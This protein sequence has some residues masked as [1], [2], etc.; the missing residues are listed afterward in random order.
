MLV[1]RG[2]GCAVN[3]PVALAVGNFDGVHKG[4]QAI[5][6]R[7][8]S[9]AA[10]RRLASGVLT[11]EPHPREYFERIRRGAAMPA[12]GPAPTRLTSLREKLELLQAHGLDCVHVQRFTGA[13][14]ALSPER[15]VE[16]VLVRT[17]RAKWVLVGHDFRFGARRA[18]DV[19]RLGELASKH[20]FELAVMPPVVH[21][22]LRVSSGAVREA[23]ARGDLAQAESLLGRPYSISGRVVHGDK[24]GRE[25][26]CSTAN[27]QLKH[28]HPPLTGIFAVLV[29][30]VGAGPRPGVASLGVRPTVKADGAAPVL[31]VHLL[32][33][34]GD[35]YG[36]HLRVQ[37]LHKIRDEEKFADLEALRAQIERDCGTARR[38]LTEYHG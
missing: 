18:G 10:R 25:L 35:L 20:G 33:F 24:L 30:G 9:E 26:G 27:I 37:F 38:F 14:A 15:F 29:D 4:H 2:A 34:N 32:D 17:L 19:Q 6:E 3:T 1:T 13:F 12:S 36:L 21:D 11:F 28:N 16:D 8:R 31:E 22:G 5:L 7:V 23:L